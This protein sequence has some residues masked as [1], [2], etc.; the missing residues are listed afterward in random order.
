MAET[1]RR[2]I[3]NIGTVVGN[4][5]GEREEYLG[6]PYAK[7]ER[8][9]YAEPIERI[10]GDVD[11]TRFGAS[12][13]QTRAYVDL[14][15]DPERRFYYREFREGDEYVYDEDCLNMNVYTSE[16]FNHAPV[17]LYIHGGGFNSGSNAE[18]T[19]DGK[20][21]VEKGVV[22]VAIN[23]RVGLLGFCVGEDVKSGE[24]EGNLG[25]FDQLE[26]MR[27]VKKH[28][29]SFGGDPENITL[30]G[31]S[32]GAISLQYHALS[33]LSEGLYNKIIF[34]SGGGL[35]PKFALPEKAEDIRGFYS[36]FAKLFGKT[37]LK[38][39]S[40]V[41]IEELI[42][43]FYEFKRSQKG[44]AFADMPVVDGELIDKDVTTLMQEGR[45]KSVPM[46]VSTTKHDMF[47]L[48][49]YNMAAKL[50]KKNESDTY[51][52]FFDRNMPGDDNKSFHSSDLW[53]A[54]GNTEKCWRPLEEI[55]GVLRDG[56]LT[57]FAAFCKSGN[58][59]AENLPAW[60]PYSEE[61]NRRMTFCDDG[62][63]VKK[64]SKT[65]LFFITIKN[66]KYKA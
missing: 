38:E 32:A 16:K 30:I 20:H 1:V 7:A 55:D 64:Q 50:A 66:E 3:E 9:C 13:P 41:P 48:I 27:F 63:F 26:A 36:Y 24:R 19:V 6:V 61:K 15:G 22:F 59:N 39:L 23:Y 62:I 12:C 2:E 49:L 11:C 29:S 21:Y 8:F 52:A 17:L 28:I 65:E 47:P 42:T 54:L 51:L 14:L 56:V 4:K 60:Q 40:D 25:L 5:Y 37:K 57:Y 58:P 43:K 45:L 53:Y 18:K 34:L 44:G 31:Q 33:Q 46:I 10:D 35:M